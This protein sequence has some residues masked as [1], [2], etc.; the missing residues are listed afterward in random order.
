[1]PVQ[2]DNLLL[3]VPTTTKP[4]IA[5]E[6]V[7]V[8]ELLSVPWTA[9]LSCSWDPGCCMPREQVWIG[10]KQK[11]L[12]AGSMQLMHQYC[13]WAAG[14]LAVL[15]PIFEPMGLADP[16]PAT[17]LGFDYTP[18]AIT[19]IG[20]SAVR[21]CTAPSQS[22]FTLP[23]AAGAPLLRGERALEVQGHGRVTCLTTL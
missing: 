1:M 7:L 15:V 3:H 4:I 19:A 8:E 17:L 14:L 11:E 23:H 21:P 13:P 9:E 5:T 2:A 18:A 12:Q 20:G 16:T 22:R 6:A 10:T